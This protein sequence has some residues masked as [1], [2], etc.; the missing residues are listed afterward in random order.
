[1]SIFTTLSVVGGLPDAHPLSSLV[2]GGEQPDR[3]KSQ[4]CMVLCCHAC[5]ATF[6]VACHKHNNLPA[7]VSFYSRAPWP[8]LSFTSPISISLSL[9]NIKVRLLRL[10]LDTNTTSYSE[11]LDFKTLCK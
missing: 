1:M 4:I 2:E 6:F 7:F 10:S 9:T 11:K 8:I 3:T 5:A